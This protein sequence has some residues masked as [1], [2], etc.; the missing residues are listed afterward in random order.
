MP[1]FFVSNPLQKIVILS[2]AL[3]HPMNL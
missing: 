3:C 1:G 2:E